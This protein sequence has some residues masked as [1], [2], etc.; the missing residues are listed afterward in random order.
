METVAVAVLTMEAE[1]RLNELAMGKSVNLRFR[2]IF[3]WFFPFSL[4]REID[5]YIYKKSDVWI[6]LVFCKIS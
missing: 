2:P 1:P 5:F 6:K 4:N 3:Q